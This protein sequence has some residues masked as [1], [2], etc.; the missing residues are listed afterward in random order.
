MSPKGHP[1]TDIDVVY[2]T[3]SEPVTLRTGQTIVIPKGSHW[4]ADDPVVRS[5]P[6]LFSDDP[7]YG[8]LY[9]EAPRGYD[10]DLNEVEEATA[11]P[12]ERRSVRR[13]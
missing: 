5:R 11:N 8:L 10:N 13:S 3:G 9:S 6:H 1:V 2:A 12:G 7:R 4:P